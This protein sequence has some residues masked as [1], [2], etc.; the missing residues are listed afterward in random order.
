MRLLW[1]FKRQFRSKTIF[2]WTGIFPLILAVLFSL[3]LKGAYTSTVDLSLK[4]A[5]ISDSLSS[6]VEILAKNMEAVVYQDHPMFEITQC[7]RE[8][9]MSLLEADEITGVIDVKEDDMEVFLHQNGIEQTVLTEFVASYQRNVGLMEKAIE[10]GMTFEQA[11]S[12]LMS[13]SM[14]SMLPVSDKDPASLHFFTLIGMVCMYGGFYGIRSM[15]AIGGNLSSCGRRILSSGYPKFKLILSNFFIN[16]L[17]LD[18]YVTID[19]LFMAFGLG[20]DFGSHL[21]YVLCLAYLGCFAGNGFGLVLGGCFPRMEMDM[22]DGL[23]IAISMFMSFCAG[24]MSISVKQ[25]IHQYVPLLQMVNPCYLI[26]D[27]LYSL[28]YYGVGQRFYENLGLLFAFGL[29]TTFMSLLMVRRRQY[30]AL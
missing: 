11:A 10:G 27:G 1:E 23:L 16:N 24:M 9:A 14:I 28:Y 3:V 15:R 8:K 26:S 7:S 5:L 17:I 2:F 30:D 22:R 6:N 18:A 19:I 29:I 20:V 13:E 21:S 4:V 25:I 12:L